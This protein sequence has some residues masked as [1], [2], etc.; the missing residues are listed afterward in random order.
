M[1]DKSQRTERPTAKRRKEMR[2]EGN[3]AR[4]TELGGWAALLFVASFLPQL[5][6]AITSRLLSFMQMTSDAMAHPDAEKAVGLIGNGLAT[7]AEAAVP[8]LLFA[9]VLAIAIAVT[10]V[11]LVFAPKAMRMKFSRISPKSGFS[12]I[13]SS[14]GLWTLGKTM[15]KL[16]T[17]AFVGYLII[18]RF[19]GGMLGGGTLP[20]QATLIAASSTITQ[21]MRFIGFSALVIAGADYYFERRKH[22]Q[23][24]R[25]TKQEVKKEFRENEGSPE[26]RRAQKSKARALSRQQIMAAVARADVVVTNPTHFAV[27]I[28]YDS[29]TD[30]APRVVA[31]GADFNAVAIRERAK[32][33]RVAIVE[34]PPLARTL[35]ATCEV[36]DVIPPQLY[37]AVA[38]LLAFVYSLSSTARVM[39]EVHRMSS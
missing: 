5:G 31:K 14:Q 15:L 37:A 28:A 36:D 35:H 4:S 10:Q 19:V 11:G 1:A 3:V 27:A 2:E 24:L 13:Y 20:L 12:R 6:G 16:V 38:Q 18:H 26:M 9:G 23:D 33:C 17:L 32:S 25:M 8:A 30:R 7:A 21:L 29:S 34:N 39:N 22:Q